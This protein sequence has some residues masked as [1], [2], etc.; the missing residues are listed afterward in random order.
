MGNGCHQN[1]FLQLHILQRHTAVL[2]SIVHQKLY[3]LSLSIRNSMDRDRCAYL[4]FHSTDIA[5]NVVGAKL[6]GVNDRTQCQFIG[7]AVVFFP[8]DLCDDLADAPVFTVDRY[9]HVGLIQTGQR[10]QC[11]TLVKALCLQHRHIAAVAMDHRS[12]RQQLCQFHAAVVVP[13]Q[14]QHIHIDLLQ[15]TCQ[16]ITYLTTAAQKHLPDT[17]GNNA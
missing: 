9:D 14:Q 2:C 8:A 16:I 1:I 7:D 3:G 4:V 10:Y 6:S 11:V 15:Q 17:V 13:L 5:D 12:L